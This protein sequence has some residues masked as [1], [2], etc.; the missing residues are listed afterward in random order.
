MTNRPALAL[1]A[2][3]GKRARALELAKEIEQRDYAGIYCPS[4]GDCIALCEALAFTTSSIFFGTSIH[5]IYYRNP[6]DLARTAAFIHETANGRFRLGIG[7]SH[8]PMNDYLGITSTGKPLADMRQYVSDMRKAEKETGPLPPIVLAT[9]RNKM[10]SLA[11]E[12]AQGAVWANGACSYVAKQLDAQSKTEIA[13]P[14]FIG[15]MIPTVIDDDEQAAAAVHRKTLT[16][17]VQL[18]NYRNY[19]RAAGY[20]EEMDGIEAALER[21]DTDEL[22][23]NMS[24]RW[25]QDVTLYG[26]ASKVRDGVEAWRDAGVTTPILVPSSTKGGQLKAFEEIFAAFD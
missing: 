22:T 4:Y 21:G 23:K 6:I 15:D 14:F 16:M 3:P 5:P 8:K 20:E 26:S 1:I 7:V 24:D 17:Y 18:P 19:W 13:D 12:Q 2:A 10:L 11:V 25:L 9:L